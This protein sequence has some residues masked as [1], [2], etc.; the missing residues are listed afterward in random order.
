MATDKD[1][2]LL[3]KSSGLGRGEIDLGEK[4]MAS[5]LNMIIESGRIPARIIC[6]NSG[7]FLTTEGTGVAGQMAKFEELGSE[8][9]SC[10]TCLD[11]FGRREKL[12]YG[13]ST[14]MRMTV[15]SLMTFSTV[16]EP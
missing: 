3:I 11:Y 14:D 15:E 8:I 6:L 4:L 5:F 9:L 12:L 1:L 13:K 16:I 10:G 2:L 7:I